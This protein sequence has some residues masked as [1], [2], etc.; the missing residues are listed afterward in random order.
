MCF[1]IISIVI[2]GQ[3]SLID[4]SA[5]GYTLWEL[6]HECISYNDSLGR[7]MLINR[8][9]NPSGAL[10]AHSAPGDLSFWVHELAY[11]QSFGP[12]RYPTAFAGFVPYISF[13]VLDGGTWYGFGVVRWNDWF[14]QPECSIFVSIPVHKAVVKE[15][16]NS[17]LIVIGLTANSE[18]LYWT[19]TPTLD[20]IISSDTIATG[21]GYVGFDINNGIAYVFYYTSSGLYY[22][23][24]VDGITWSPEFEWIIPFSPPYSGFIHYI[25]LALTDNGE[26]RLIFDF[27]STDDPIYPYYSHI[28]VSCASGIPPIDLTASLPDT[29][30]M[31]PTIACSGNYAAA[32]FNIPRNDLPDSLAW[33]DI[34]MT[35]STDNGITWSEPRNITEWS[36]SRIGLQQIAKR[37]DLIRN[38]VYYIF[39]SD[40]IR[41]HDPFWHIWV[42]GGTD[43][44]YIYLGY[45]S[46]L[47]IEEAKRCAQRR[48]SK[49]VIYPNPFRKST[50]ISY[51]SSVI[52]DQLLLRPRE[53]QDRGAMTND[54]QYPVL[55]IY[56]AT[57]RLVKQFD[58][59]TIRQSNHVIWN[60]DNQSGQKL[61][62]GV[63]F[64]RLSVADRYRTS[65]IIKL[66]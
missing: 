47:G 21:A 66:E 20:S 58:Y 16:S 54:L 37:I 44:M 29:E 12:G 57:G 30:A 31:Y 8:A 6:R 15:F 18:I 40:K 35:I 55:R 7:L 46:V 10:N 64:V 42:Y 52:N 32:I 39:A 43:P 62:A 4:S 63:Y 1:S 3:F 27:W 48:T 34:W 60:G 25:Q 50:V 5:N 56:D 26:P 24:T 9:Y 22:R 17:S 11:N 13:P 19:F 23:T 59:P 33:M 36:T 28:Y 61:P 45:A 41:N 51:S 53:S 38:R 49:L 14:N 2:I 65:K